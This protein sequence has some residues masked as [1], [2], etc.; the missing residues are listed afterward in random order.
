MILVNENLIVIDHLDISVPRWTVRHGSLEGCHGR[1]NVLAVT[2]WVRPNVRAPVTRSV[3]LH[4][5]KR[6]AI[7]GSAET[8]AAHGSDET[9]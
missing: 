2:Y 7:A 3:A 9:S 1:L 8:F 5:T 4:D 6:I